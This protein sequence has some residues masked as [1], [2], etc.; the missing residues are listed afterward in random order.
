MRPLLFT[1][2]E[3]EAWTGEK[4][5]LRSPRESSR[6]G[7]KGPME[8]KYSLAPADTQV[9]LTLT[10]SVGQGEGVTC[11][12]LLGLSR[13]SLCLHLDLG[14]RGRVGLKGLEG[15]FGSNIL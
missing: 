6:A 15:S 5:G 10:A 7:A 12:G 2:E 1:D 3:S 14:E 13:L 8:L 11:L 4:D 9:L